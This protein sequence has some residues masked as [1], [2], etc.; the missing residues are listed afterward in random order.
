MNHCNEERTPL[1]RLLHFSPSNNLVAR[2][3]NF[4]F[5][6]NDFELLNMF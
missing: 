2:W 3:A 5:L 6:K 4:L 1:K